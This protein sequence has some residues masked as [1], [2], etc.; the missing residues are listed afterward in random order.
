MYVLKHDIS[1][2]TGLSRLV[3]ITGHGRNRDADVGLAV[4]ANACS[5]DFLKSFICSRDP[6]QVIGDL[7]PECYPMMR[8]TMHPTPAL[9]EEE[10]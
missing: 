9:N 10:K 8:P 1:L 4:S 3:S 6:S 7:Q 5:K 2:G